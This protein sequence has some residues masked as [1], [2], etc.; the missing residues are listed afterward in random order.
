MA[1]IFFNDKAKIKAS[2]ML[3]RKNLEEALTEKPVSMTL[4]Y[5]RGVGSRATQDECI[6]NGKLWFFS[7]TIREEGKP[8]RYWNAFGFDPENKAHRDI[9]AELNSPVND[10]SPY[11]HGGFAFDSEDEKQVYLVH[12]GAFSGKKKEDF[13]A[14]FDPLP[15]PV[16]SPTGQRDMLVIANLNS[17]NFIQQITD[18]L[19]D[20]EAFKDS[21]ANNKPWKKKKPGTRVSTPYSGY[22]PE[23]QSFAGADYEE[24]FFGKGKANHKGGQR[25]VEYKQEEVVKALVKYLHGQPEGGKGQN[26]IRYGSIFARPQRSFTCLR[27]KN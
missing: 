19:R 10:Y 4:K 6:H 1:L 15:Q 24:Q 5:N 8:P 17:P 13:L 21:M 16:L 27:N 14:G 20:V 22:D 12:N 11:V 7:T 18:F 3:L 23:Q 25:N 26:R 2:Q 9:V